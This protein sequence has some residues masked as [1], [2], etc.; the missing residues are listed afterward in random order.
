[1]ALPAV[2]DGTV[3]DVTVLLSTDDTGASS[4][5]LDQPATPAGGDPAASSVGTWGP[6]Q[7]TGCSTPQPAGTVCVPG[8]AYWMG[9]ASGHLTPGASAGWRRL[10]V[11]SPF[12]L[13][14]TEV[15]VAATRAHGGL[16]GVIAWSG[17]TQGTSYADFCTYSASPTRRDVL[18]VNCVAPFGAEDYC[19]R[20][21][22]HLPSE[23]QLEYVS[24]GAFGRPYAW[25][26][27]LPGCG[28]VIWGR[29]GFGVYKLVLPSTCRSSSNFLAPMGGPE[30]PGSG[31]I[32]VVVLPGGSVVDLAGNVYEIARDTYE[33]AED[34][35]WSSPGVMRDPVCLAQGATIAVRGG[36][37]SVGGTYLE[38]GHRTEVDYDG[39]TPEAG[40]RCAVPGQ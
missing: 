2:P 11:V 34:P 13:D 35:C 40:F 25:G 8:G 19:T 24:G 26:Y 1:M 29:D 30:P 9:A 22:G 37:W 36:A 14:T 31:A 10:V 5:S 15:T 17:S 16:N 23:A 21:G 18:P 3:A 27:D 20:R 7:R 6:A 38:A 39:D 28:D 33:L 4:S 12:W 32:D